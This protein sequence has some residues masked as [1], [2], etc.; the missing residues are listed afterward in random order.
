MIPTVDLISLTHVYIPF[1]TLDIATA[2]SMTISVTR[3]L[4]NSYIYFTFRVRSTKLV[5]KLIT[6]VGMRKCIDH[7]CLGVQ[8]ATT[9]G[10]NGSVSC[11]VRVSIAILEST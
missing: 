8:A 9:V 5:A 10:R 6:L 1:R 4:H 7:C 2:M 11:L 3:R